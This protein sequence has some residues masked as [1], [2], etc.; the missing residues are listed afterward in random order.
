MELYGAVCSLAEIFRGQIQIAR[1]FVDV[2]TLNRLTAVLTIPECCEA[3]W[4]S[5][6]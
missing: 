2:T 3:R 1:Q 4:T 6:K 5:P